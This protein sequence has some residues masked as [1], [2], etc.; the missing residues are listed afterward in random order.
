LLAVGTRDRTVPPEQ[1][2]RIAA[3]VPGARIVELPGLGHLA[4]E[5]D[6]AQV[7]GVILRAAREHGVLGHAQGVTVAP[8]APSAPG[9]AE[10]RTTALRREAKAAAP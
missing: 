8:S 6:P 10:R 3:R 7:A 5:E 9:A 1:A 4:H 2:L